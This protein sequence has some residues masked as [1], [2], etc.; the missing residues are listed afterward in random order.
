LWT[1]VPSLASEGEFNWEPFFIAAN[2]DDPIP[3]RIDESL[4]RNRFGGHD[5]AGRADRDQPDRRLG[6][7]VGRDLSEH[8]VL[9][10]V[11]SLTTS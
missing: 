8:R 10:A 2:R 11:C 3:E 4:I 5:P 1:C 7:V 6:P 9:S